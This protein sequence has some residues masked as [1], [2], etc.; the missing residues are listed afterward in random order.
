MP[1]HHDCNVS[2]VQAVTG[3]VPLQVRFNA[4]HFRSKWGNHSDERHFRV[5][6]Y[7]DC[8]VGLVQAL[9]QSY[10]RFAMLENPSSE[11]V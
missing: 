1:A 2:L 3:M 5:P 4:K 6:A 10:V 8:N 9:D 11:L 7:H